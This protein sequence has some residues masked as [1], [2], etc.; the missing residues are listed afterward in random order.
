MSHA[1]ST[2]RDSRDGQNPPPPA[3]SSQLISARL[4]LPRILYCLRVLCLTPV[5]PNRLYL[6]TCFE[7]ILDRDVGY[8]WV[9]FV[10]LASV[11]LA[12]LDVNLDMALLE[13]L[14]QMSTRAT[15][16]LEVSKRGPCFV[17]LHASKIHAAGFVVVVVCL[18][19]VLVTKGGDA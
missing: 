4:A 10:R 5:Q 9:N 15:E 12:P 19:E 13:A 2:M 8:A 18:M 7:A 3:S 1:A 11:R 14:L 6:K 16:L 17:F